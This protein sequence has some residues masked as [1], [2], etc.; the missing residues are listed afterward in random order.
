MRPDAGV[1]DL[2]NNL[3]STNLQQSTTSDLPSLAQTGGATD[4]DMFWSINGF[5]DSHL[6]NLVDVMN[7]DPDFM[8]AQDYSVGDDASET[9]TWEKWDT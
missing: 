7:M 4:D 6:C 9:I 3:E 5:D 1:I 2:S 8:L